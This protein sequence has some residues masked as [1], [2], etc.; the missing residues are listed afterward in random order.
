VCSGGRDVDSHPQENQRDWIR[1][2]WALVQLKPG[3]LM[4][5]DIQTVRGEQ[6]LDYCSVVEADVCGGGRDVDSH[7]NDQLRDVIRCD[8]MRD[9]KP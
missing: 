8:L 3:T 4:V 9:Q 7:S 6:C 2:P 5:V 1:R